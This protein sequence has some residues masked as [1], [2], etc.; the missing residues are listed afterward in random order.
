MKLKVKRIQKR[1]LTGGIYYQIEFSADLSPEELELIKK[2][3]LEKEIVY[4]PGD[5]QFVG[6]AGIFKKNIIREVSDSM[7]GSKKVKEMLSKHFENI[8]IGD[9][10]KGTNIKCS[11]LNEI[12]EVENAIKAA[13]E[14]LKSYIKLAETFDGREIVYE[15]E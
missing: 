2:Y 4:E 10:V 5:Y 9:L 14:K 3:K 12:I 15:I 7:L 11:D 1:G 13:C 6:S 8:K